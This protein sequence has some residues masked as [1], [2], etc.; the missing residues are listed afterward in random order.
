MSRCSQICSEQRRTMN[1]RVEHTGE[2]T[3][4][5]SPP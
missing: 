3:A 1:D 4:F 2:N 5:P